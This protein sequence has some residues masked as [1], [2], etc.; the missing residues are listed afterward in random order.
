[1]SCGIALGFLDYIGMQCFGEVN[2][3]LVG[4][5]HQHPQYVGQLIGQGI[6]ILAGLERLEA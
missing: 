3:G 1:M 6:G 4:N 5:S 2:P